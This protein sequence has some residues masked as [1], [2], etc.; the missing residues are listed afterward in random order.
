MSAQES[1]LSQTLQRYQWE[2]RMIVYLFSAL[3]IG[4]ALTVSL[5]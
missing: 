5:R 3:V 4:A 1:R 2:S